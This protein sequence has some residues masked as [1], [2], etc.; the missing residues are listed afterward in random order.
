MHDM[1]NSEN[2]GLRVLLVDDSPTV[3]AVLQRILRRTADVIV[4]GEAEDGEAGVRL[5][6]ELAPDIV[7]MDLAMPRV[8]GFVATAEIMHRAPTAILVF[9]SDA[10]VDGRRIFDAYSRGARA[11]LPKPASPEGWTELSETLPELIR[12]VV[13][14]FENS[15]PGAGAGRRYPAPPTS[16]T[17]TS[18]STLT[19]TWRALFT[20]SAIWRSA[21]RPAAPRPCAS[22]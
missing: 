3:R 16:S 4:V 19:L 22:C 10:R 14:D 8:D 7:L 17:S 11:V 2:H 12:N 13:H 20:R 9:S 6:L 1:K 21:P 18:I 5:A 15:R